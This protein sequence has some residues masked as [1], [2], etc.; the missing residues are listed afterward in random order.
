MNDWIVALAGASL[1]IGVFNLWLLVDLRRRDVGVSAPPPDRD[2]FR[3]ELE[4]LELRLLEI[5]NG[6]E[7]MSRLRMYDTAGHSGRSYE[8]AHRMASRGATVEQVALDCGLSIE[9]AELIVRL[10]RE[11]A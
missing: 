9:E 1:V 5:G 11:G 7:R 8:L 3:G 4:Q 2:G 10:H 6:V